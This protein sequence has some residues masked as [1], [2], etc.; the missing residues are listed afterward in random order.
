MYTNYTRTH[1]QAHDVHYTAHIRL[2]FGHNRKL[3]CTLQ[4]ICMCTHIAYRYVKNETM[5]MPC[6]T[7]NRDRIGIGISV[8]QLYACHA[9]VE[10]AHTLIH[11]H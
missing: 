3:S 4:T 8:Q 11:S 6:H 5:T 10:A 7:S 1:T 2:A 9:S